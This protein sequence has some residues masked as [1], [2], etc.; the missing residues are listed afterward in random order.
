MS[1]KRSNSFRQIALS[2]SKQP[3]AI[4]KSG[5]LADAFAQVFGPVEHHFI[6]DGNIHRLDDPTGR[7]GNQACWYVLYPQPCSYAIFG[8]WRYGQNYYTDLRSPDFKNVKPF[9][10]LLIEQSKKQHADTAARKLRTAVASVLADRMV[11]HRLTG[12]KEGRWS[13][14]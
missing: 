2:N 3:S 10:K 4:V 1:S 7:P 14:P 12:S 13:T 11:R 6:A 8:S 5:S 9:R